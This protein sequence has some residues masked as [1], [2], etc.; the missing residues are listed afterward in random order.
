MY[1]QFEQSL[2]SFY[3]QSV[4]IL[5]AVAMSW[6]NLL[7]TD[8][9]QGKGTNLSKWLELTKRLWF[10]RVIQSTKV[11]CRKSTSS[12]M[13][14][15]SSLSFA[16][17]ASFLLPF[18]SL[19]GLNSRWVLAFLIPSLHVISDSVSVFLPGP[20]SLLPPPVC[21]LFMSEFCHELL[22]HLCR[23]PATST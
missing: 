14:L 3:R 18:V 2:L 21:F 1:S 15:F 19:T 23:P 9:V 5:K 13:P 16:V 7:L 12:S 6:L 22:V 8:E 10:L 17:Q 4:I 20:V 11:V